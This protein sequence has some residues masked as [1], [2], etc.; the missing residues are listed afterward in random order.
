MMCVCVVRLEFDP[1]FVFAHGSG[2]I[3]FA[4]E[5]HFAERG[6]RFGKIGIKA[7]SFE[8]RFFRFRTRLTP[9]RA[10]VK[11]GQ[12]VGARKTGVRQRIIWIAHDRL[13]DPNYALAYAG[14]SSAYILAP[15]YAG[16]D[17]RE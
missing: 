10:S 7:E 12:N 16:A 9:V 14:L 2:Q 4:K 1:S 3:D 5:E 13:L 6:V 15:F 8:G 17:R 11:G